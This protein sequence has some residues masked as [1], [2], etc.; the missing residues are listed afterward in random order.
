MMEASKNA[1]RIRLAANLAGFGV[2]FTLLVVLVG[3]GTRL[4]DAGL[5]CPDWPGCYGTLVV[6]DGDRAAAFAPDAPLDSFKAWVEMVHRYLATALGLMALILA[7][8]AF[9]SRKTPGYPVGLSFLLLFAVCV[10]GAFGA[11]TVTLKLWP[12]V[13][14]LHLLGGFTVL[15]LFFWLQR[16]LQACARGEQEARRPPLLWWLV[17]LL[18]AGQ[19]ALGGW[20]SSN[21]AGL[22]CG[23]FPTCNQQW[24]SEQLDFT[25][26]FHVTQEVGPN[27]LHGQLHA[28]ARTAIHWTHRV[29]A[30]ALGVGLVFLFFL[31][32]RQQRAKPWLQ[33]LLVSYGVQAGLGVATVIWLLPLTLAILHTAG[34]ALLLLTLLMT[35]WQLGFSGLKVP[36]VTLTEVDNAQFQ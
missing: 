7:W 21:Y 23:G 20:T 4:V 33:L 25:E 24:W 13:V 5:G 35:G 19:V 3:A 17:L 6:P 31:Y 30:L 22:A 12:Q 1:R 10:Q 27:Y 9:K 28:P 15:A 14:T 32:L 11:W 16:R 2:L 8:V 34:A 36:K 26:G 29:G 18:L